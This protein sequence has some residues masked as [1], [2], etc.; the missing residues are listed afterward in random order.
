MANRQTLTFIEAKFLIDSFQFVTEHTGVNPFIN[1]P[2]EI[3]QKFFDRNG[4][5]NLWIQKIRKIRKMYSPD[6]KIRIRNSG[7]F[8]I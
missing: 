5:Y 8:E 6:Y 4:L 2:F 7:K 1:Q 3:I